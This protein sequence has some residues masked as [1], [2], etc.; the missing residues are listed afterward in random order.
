MLFLVSPV[1]AQPVVM[2]FGDSLSAGFGLPNGKG[3]VDHLQKRLMA[4]QYPHQVIN[5]SIS[6]D[7]TS[8]GVSRIQRALE[9]HKP[10]IVIVELGA[11]DGLRGLSLKEMRDNLGLILEKIAQT[12]AKTLLIGMQLPPNY[13]VAFTR[14][15]AKSFT[16]VSEH[17]GTPLVPFLMAG[18]A[19]DLEYFQADRFHPNV[20]A[21]PI[22]LDNIW[23][24]LEKLL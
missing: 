22:L 23:P 3:W 6:G 14:Q 7:T 8:G 1:Y 2:V 19:T 5:A 24:Y 15:Y 4:K 11:N 10:N 16:T 18:I 17:H 20:K 9:T 12:K 13:G 21:Q